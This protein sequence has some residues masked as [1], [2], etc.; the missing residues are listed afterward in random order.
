[1]RAPS[2]TVAK[3][4]RVVFCLGDDERFDY[5]YK[6]VTA[7]AFNPDDRAGNMNLLDD[8]ILYVAQFAEDGTLTWLPLVHGQA[9]LTAENGFASQ[10]DILIETRRAADLLGATKMDRPEDI[11]P[12]PAAG[13]TY[14][15]LT[16]NNKR[17]S[18]GRERRQPACQTTSSEHMIEM[19]EKEGDFAATSDV[20]DPPEMRRSLGRPGRR[21][22]LGRDNGENGWFGMPDTCAVDAEGRLW[23]ATDGNN[24]ADYGPSPTA[25]GRSI[26]RV[27]AR[28]TSKLFFRA[29]IGA[30][31]CGPLLTPEYADDVPCRAAPR[32]PSGSDWQPFGRPSYF[33]DLSTRWPDLQD[34]MPPRPSVLV[35]TKQGG[36][37]IAG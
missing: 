35:I 20:G 16:S 12:N 32:R 7:G 19:S 2:S 10:A 28:A 1:M 17:N 13:K 37:K 6:F 33:E 14:L 11:Q 24:P 26:P 18:G 5:V 34:G 30:E 27:D 4:G 8:G 3:N 21:H 31:I 25:F 36:G 15:M 22:L 9:P 23:V 29:P